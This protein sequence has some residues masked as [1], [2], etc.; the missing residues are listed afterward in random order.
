MWDWAGQ[1]EDMAHQEFSYL[2][3]CLQVFT[4]L[5]VGQLCLLFA[6]SWKGASDAVGYPVLE[7]L[8]SFPAPALFLQ[9]HIQL[10][11]KAKLQTTRLQ[12]IPF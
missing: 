10:S 11:L 12:M 2:Q 7:A 9:F 4:K 1:A 5:Q 3:F 6:E 8:G